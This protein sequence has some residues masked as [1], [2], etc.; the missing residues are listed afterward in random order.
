MWVSVVKDLKLIRMSTD[1]PAQHF[2]LK[3]NQLNKALEMME[4]I[5]KLI[6]S[7]KDAIILF[8]FELN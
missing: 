2:S 7:N 5:R 1:F 3:F 8:C 6:C 4:V